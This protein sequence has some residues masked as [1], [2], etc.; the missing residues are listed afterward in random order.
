M[1]P[2][3]RIDTPMPSAGGRVDV[4]VAGILAENVLVE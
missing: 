2:P 3:A 1:S 4:V